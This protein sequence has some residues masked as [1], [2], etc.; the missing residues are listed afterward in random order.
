MDQ[1]IQAGRTA[2]TQSDRIKAY[3]EIQDILASELPWVFL[4][5]P[6]LLV[7]HQPDIAN[8]KQ[9]RQNVTGLPWDNPL[10]NAAHWTRLSKKD[11]PD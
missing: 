11:R 7:A 3:K 8:I 10:F 4:V 6:E 9:G 5:Q 2:R 1:L